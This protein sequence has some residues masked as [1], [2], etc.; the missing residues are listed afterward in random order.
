[1]S[2]SLPERASIICTGLLGTPNWATLKV[3]GLAIVGTSNGHVYH[4]RLF[5]YNSA[6]NFSICLDCNPSYDPQDS[7]RAVVTI[8]YKKYM[9]TDSR[10]A[11]GKFPKSTGPFNTKLKASQN[12]ETILKLLFN[13]LERD[14]Y[15]LD[16][17][18][19][20]R[21]WC[22]TILGDLEQRSYVANDSTER[23]EAW[24]ESKKS[25][26]GVGIFMMPRQKGAFYQ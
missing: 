20:C 12:V 23:F 17:G 7:D 24:E 4:F 9:Y 15:R 18:L 26:L 14:K 8:G 19:G 16:G 21:H 3:D 11:P 5:I 22:A 2:G 25:E 13:N 6:S 1:M 10:N